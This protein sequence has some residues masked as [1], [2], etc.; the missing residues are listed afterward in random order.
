[1]LQLMG[2]RDGCISPR[3]AEGQSAFCVSL[4]A[5]VVSGV[6]HF[7]HFEAPARIGAR[8]DAAFRG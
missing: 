3:V 8:I 6:G 1:M 4:E 2:A 7:L 5:E